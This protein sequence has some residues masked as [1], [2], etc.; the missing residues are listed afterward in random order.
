M[1]RFHQA[2]KTVTTVQDGIIPETCGYDFH[3]VIE[4]GEAKQARELMLATVDFI[5]SELKN[6]SHIY[7]H[8][9][10]QVNRPVGPW[11]KP[12]WEIQLFTVDVNQSTS[13][14][15]AIEESRQIK[16]YQFMLRVAEF[17]K[18][19]IAQRGLQGSL[20]VHAN[21]WPI[22]S[23]LALERELHF[24]K[25][26]LVCGKPVDL[27]DIWNGPTGWIAVETFVKEQLQAGKTKVEEMTLSF[28]EKFPYN[29]VHQ[30]MRVLDGQLNLAAMKQEIS[31]Q[32]VT[33]QQLL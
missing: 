32:N 12:M 3:Y 8:D 27:I 14:P 17:L 9:C 18:K 1:Y 24:P 25:S 11:K 29:S 5:D 22:N 15:L 28:R 10:G 33:E 31:E 19:E 6:T 30:L 2:S 21:N 13:D 16:I 26:W 4:N 23:N 20:L 7:N